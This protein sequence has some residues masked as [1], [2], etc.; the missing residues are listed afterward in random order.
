MTGAA[1]ARGAL[2]GG[3]V[4]ALRKGADASS[5]SLRVAGFLLTGELASLTET[6]AEGGAARGTAAG[7]GFDG[8]DASPAFT[9]TRRF[10]TVA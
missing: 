9:A 6:G 8:A 10:T 1:L 4:G 5:S 3:G 2:A 7:A